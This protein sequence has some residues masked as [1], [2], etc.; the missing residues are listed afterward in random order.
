MPMLVDYYIEEILGEGTLEEDR[1]KL[2]EAVSFIS[3][4]EDAVE[5]NLFI[6]KVSEKL[7]VDQEVLKTEVQR[8]FSHVPGPQAEQ[9]RRRT[10]MQIDHL[11]LSLI[12]MILE[13]PALIPAVADSGVLSWFTTEE[14]KS[15][16]EAL[17]ATGQRGGAAGDVSSR[18]S[19]LAEGP[20]REKLLE[21][22]VRESPYQEELMDRL[23]N[24]TIR[25]IRHKWYKE[26]HRILRQRIVKAEEA[27]N[28]E[29]CDS[30][31][32][33]KGRL[34]REEKMLC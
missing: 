8:V 21:L 33:E 1:D 26:R 30:L 23:I 19:L 24:D 20:V 10:P 34:L 18:V 2:R 11:E 3:R 27:G 5:R 7:N 29:M 17:L 9:L 4:M 32:Q 25:Q 31:L 14:L 28:R 15:F 22:L 6:K 13:C 16:G 12:H